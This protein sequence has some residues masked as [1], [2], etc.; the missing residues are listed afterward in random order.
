MKLSCVLSAQRDSLWFAANAVTL[1]LWL[2]SQRPPTDHCAM[3]RPGPPPNW[4]A[5]GLTLDSCIRLPMTPAACTLVRPFATKKLN[6]V[7]SELDSAA[8]D[9]LG[10]AVPSPGLS[11][12]GQPVMP[13]DARTPSDTQRRVSFI[14]AP[15]AARGVPRG[16]P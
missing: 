15:L 13:V 6:A 3:P 4:M 10:S 2:V 7:C 12:V 5:L 1:S 14:M 9:M 11:S 16:A 8:S